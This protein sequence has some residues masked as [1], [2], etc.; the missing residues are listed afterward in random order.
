MQRSISGGAYDHVARVRIEAPKSLVDKHVP[1]SVGTVT[2]EGPDRCIFEAG[3]NNLGAMA[4][5]L[6]AM[7]WEL[8]VLDPPELRDVMREQAARMLRAARGAGAGEAG[9]TAR[10]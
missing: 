2:A 1:A 4:M 6:G 10:A 3:G 9:D 8:T 5:H 7:P